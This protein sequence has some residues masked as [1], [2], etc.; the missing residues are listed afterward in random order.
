MVIAGEP[1][2]DMRAA[3]VIS[4]VQR[5]IPTVKWF[6]IGGPLMRQIGVETRYDIE[7]MA[8]MGISEVLRRYSFF[9]R[10]FRE[11]IEWA[12]QR[13]P[14]MALFIDYPG[15]NLRLA[16]QLHARGIKTVYY[17]CPQVWAWH[18]S[19]IPKMAEYLDLLL[20][21]FPF[22]AEHFQ[23]TS[24]PVTYVGHPLVDSIEASNQLPAYQLPWNGIHRVALLPGSRK[25]EIAYLLPV[26]LE[27]AAQLEQ[28]IH[29]CGFL[30]AA[31]GENQIQQIS[32]ILAN[33]SAKPPEVAI[34][35]EHTRDVI[36]QA[37]A[38]MVCSGTAT[39]ETALLNCPMVVCYKTNILTYCI[40][41]PL[42]R[43]PH[44]GMVN[45]VAEKEVCPELVQGQLTP[46]KLANNIEKLIRHGTERKEMLAHL[47][48]V[49]K[50]IGGP[51]AAA[52][53][54]Q[55]ITDIV[56]IVPEATQMEYAWF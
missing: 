7:D 13:K 46:D 3:E 35:K 32:E 53:A 43:I 25:Q 38:A 52:H 31:A 4:A 30:V 56:G 33:T 44:I 12:E 54:A 39:L 8:V 41:K 49:Q 28:R 48:K 29:D 36:A 42:I 27:A 47:A 21:I 26:M 23:T 50:R 6:G 10:A 40:M 17:I 16:K 22:E 11:M 18:R 51:G 45:I 15:F 19:R 24:L 2:G 55:I 9:R 1:S 14:D 20:S 34:V 37:D 5:N